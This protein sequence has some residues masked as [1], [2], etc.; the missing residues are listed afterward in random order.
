M[1]KIKVLT[2]AAALAVSAMSPALAGGAG[3]P[4]IENEVFVEP[5]TAPAGSLGGA[6]VA[7]AVLGVVLLGA[8]IASSNGT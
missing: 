5:A 1:K 7:A 8:A 3:A 4:V 2:V 6:G